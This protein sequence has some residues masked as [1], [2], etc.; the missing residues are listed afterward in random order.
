MTIRCI[1]AVAIAAA[2]L[3]ASSAQAQAQKPAAPTS[4]TVISPVFSQLVSF[5]M[6]S[7]FVAGYEKSTDANYTR[8]AVP[9]GETL[10]KWSEMITVTGARGLASAPN[11]SAENFAATMA[12]GFK[13]VCPDSFSAQALGTARIGGNDTYAAVIGCGRIKEGD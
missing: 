6:P 5:S 13:K 1:N 8:E 3:L 12:N 2:G 11:A 9:K 10:T 7:D 4:F